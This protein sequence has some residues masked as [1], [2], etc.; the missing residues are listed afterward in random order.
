MV[1]RVVVHPMRPEPLPW[2]AS[3]FL[4]IPVVMGVVLVAAAIVMWQQEKAY[5]SEGVTAN[6]E[7]TS[8]WTVPGSDSGAEY[9]LAYE[10]ATASGARYRGSETVSFDTYRQA[11]AGDA[12]VVSYLASRPGTNRITNAVPAFLPVG[13]GTLGA[14]MASF[15]AWVFA[16]N[17]TRLRASRA[18]AGAKPDLPTLP[19]VM[20][21]F[22]RSALRV[23]VDLLGPPLGAFCFLAGV[24]FIGIANVSGADF[25]TRALFVIGFGFF[26]VL[27]LSGVPSSIRRGLRP[28]V[29]EVGPD[30]I[31]TPEMGRL[32]WVEVA[33]VRLESVGGFSGD[34]PGGGTTTYHRL[35][36]VPVDPARAAAVRRSPA[37]SLTQGFFNFVRR[38]RPGAD[39]PDPDEIAPFGVYDYDLGGSLDA[40]AAAVR[41]YREVS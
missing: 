1:E 19:G 22:T 34:D 37:W 28:A 14:L 12:I 27:L 21:V 3:L 11:A 9:H 39:V 29:L 6:G 13:L 26:G 38:L 17:T 10:F 24:W 36:V 8:K 25:A 18:V 32:G 41:L 2:R 30:G 33:Q 4:L 20:Y 23:A 31:W 16:R 15:G 7:V 40:A 5:G 35:G